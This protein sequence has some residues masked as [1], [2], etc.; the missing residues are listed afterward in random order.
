MPGPDPGIGSVSGDRLGAA[1]PEQALAA[2]ARAEAELLAYP[3][4]S[5]VE[6]V[7]VDG[8]PCADVLVVGGGQSGLV[9]AHGLRRSGVTNVAVLD[10]RPAGQE[11]V[12]EHFARM[13]ELRT[14]KYQNGADLGQ[15]SLSVQKWFQARYGLEAWDRVVRIP[16]H[17]WMDYLRWYR[18]TLDLPVE[19]D[20]AVVDI[21]PGP[22]PG[23]LAIE[24]SRGLR[25]ARSV[26]L[27][28]GFEG[29]GAWKIPDAV[30]AALPPDRHD[31]ACTPI[32]FARFRGQRIGVLGHGASA[33]DAAV[34]ALRE[35]AASVDLCFRRPAL[36][37][38]NPHRHLESAGMMAHWPALSDRTRWNIAR[39]MRLFDQPPATGS[40]N[41]AMS[42]PGF[43]LHAASPW[44]DVTLDGTAIRVTTP[45]RVFLFDHV[46]CATGY[47]LD[48]PARPELRGL[49]DKV[50]LWRERFQPVA[51]EAHPD[52]DAFPYLGEGYEFQ[53]RDPAD[54]WVGRVHAFNFA[55][56]VSMGPHST[57]ISGQKHALPRVVR[58]LVRR[59]LLEQ[60]EGIVAALRAYDEPDLILKEDMHA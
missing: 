19:N 26:V 17:D 28:T 22:R 39:H 52:L 10:S 38:V 41:T 49:A 16:R 56:F 60:E 58:A 7:S 6:P 9:I 24:T 55:A 46:I 37:V 14:P 53:P 23:V 47:K 59:L 5:W 21:G 36:P 13:H 31:H 11:G 20:I 34:V 27:A 45:R 15:P 54:A 43:A 18:D 42:L 3:D 2:Q 57:S 12:W 30:T 32:D 35:G 4:R 40:Y 50:V 48:L 51:A 29:G 8:V 25:L 1:S 44:D 33:F